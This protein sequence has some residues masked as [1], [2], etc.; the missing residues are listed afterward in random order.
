MLVAVPVAV[1]VGVAVLPAGAVAVGV[2]VGVEVSVGLGVFVGVGVLV[3]AHTWSS[4]SWQSCLT[5]QELPLHSFSRQPTSL[6]PWQ[7]LNGSLSLPTSVSVWPGE[8]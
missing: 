5:L 6:L 4:L 7:S 2:L 8:P 3:G 1:A